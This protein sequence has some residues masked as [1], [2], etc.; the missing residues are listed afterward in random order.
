MTAVDAI[1]SVYWECLNYLG[2]TKQ[3]HENGPL[4]EGKKP[5]YNVW[6][7]PRMVFIVLRD[8]NSVEGPPLSEE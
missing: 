8:K 4:S 3:I 7:T 1:L 5:S 2:I 6:I